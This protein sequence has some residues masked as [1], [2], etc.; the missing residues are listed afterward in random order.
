MILTILSVILL[1]VGIVLMIVGNKSYKEWLVYVGVILMVTCTATTLVCFGFILHAQIEKEAEIEMKRSEY[2]TL[3]YELEKFN[4]EDY[5]LTSSINFDLFPRI[6]E[7]NSSIRASE[8]Y[9][10]S[11]WIN[12]FCIDYYNYLPT[13]ELS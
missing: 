6:A 2:E 11:I 5:S 9:T 13:I 8:H 7:Y 3:T 1:G 12:W 4:D 10:K